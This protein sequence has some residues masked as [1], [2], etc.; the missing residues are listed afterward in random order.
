MLYAMEFTSVFILCCRPQQDLPGEE[1]SDEGVPRASLA[2]SSSEAASGP[3]PAQGGLGEATSHPPPP[4][5]VV[6]G[7]DVI[8]AE[9][10]TS[11]FEGNTED[12]GE[13]IPSGQD[14]PV[15]HSPASPAPALSKPQGHQGVPPTPSAKD[16]ARVSPPPQLGLEGVELSGH[17]REVETAITSSSLLP[18]HRAV[19]GT[20]LTKFRSAETEMLNAVLGLV[21]GFEVKTFLHIAFTALLRLA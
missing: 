13:K 12:R 7:L 20:V 5:T 21:K 6:G 17:Q 3:S 15:L 14:E 11:A 16:I 1:D 18:E 10:D 2:Q 4:T 9:V 8:M 19:L